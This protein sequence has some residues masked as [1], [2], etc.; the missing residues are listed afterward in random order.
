M[1]SLGRY[2]VLKFVKLFKIHLDAGRYM[3]SLGNVRN[4]NVTKLGRSVTHGITRFVCDSQAS[5]A[6]DSIING[7]RSILNAY[8]AGREAI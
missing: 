4:R 8:D 1:A 2:N 7:Y 5:Y 6:R 3:K